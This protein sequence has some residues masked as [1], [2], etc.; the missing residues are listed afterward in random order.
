MLISVQIED[1]DVKD[2]ISRLCEERT[3]IGAIV[4]FSGL[5]RDRSERQDLVALELEHYPGMTE[6]SLQAIADMAMERWDIDDL[7][8]VHRVGRLEPADNI[9]LVVVIS[10]HRKQAFDACECLMDYLKTQAPFWKKEITSQGEAWV[11]AKQS[12][13]DAASSWQD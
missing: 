11:E 3:D 9:V 2:I 8:V 5:V 13:S 10:A 7:A 6:K 12:D 4:T 1:F